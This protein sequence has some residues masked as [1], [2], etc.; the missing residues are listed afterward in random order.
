MFLASH[1]VICKCCQNPS[2]AQ[3]EMFDLTYFLE[4]LGLL[5]GSSL[6]HN[7]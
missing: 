2:S 6:Q 4:N 7:M 1:G 5:A 3:N